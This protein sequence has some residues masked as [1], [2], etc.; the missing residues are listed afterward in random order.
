MIKQLCAYGSTKVRT[1]PKA[2]HVVDN[3]GVSRPEADKF[4]APAFQYPP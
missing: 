3:D 2:K 4:A 1:G